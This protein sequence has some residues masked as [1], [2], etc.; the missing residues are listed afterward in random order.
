MEY[1]GRETCNLTLFKVPGGY[2]TLKVYT[3]GEHLLRTEAVVPRKSWGAADPSPLSPHR[4]PPAGD[5]GEVSPSALLDGC[6]LHR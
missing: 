4:L 2:L 5:L 6:L 1:R 3:Q